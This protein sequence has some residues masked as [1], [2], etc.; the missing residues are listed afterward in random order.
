MALLQS[1][2]GPDKRENVRRFEAG[3]LSI[4]DLSDP[5]I[6]PASACGIFEVALRVFTRTEVGTGKV[7]VVDEAHKLDNRCTISYYAG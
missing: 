6:D 4:I 2:L 1:F 3:Q 5:F 7:L